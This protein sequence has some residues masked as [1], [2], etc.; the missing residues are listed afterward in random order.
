[1]NLFCYGFVPFMGEDSLLLLDG[2]E[3]WR[4]VELMN[5]NTWIN[6]QYVFM[7]LSENVQIIFHE[8]GELLMDQRVG[9]GANM[10]IPVQMIVV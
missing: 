3:G 9:L 1:M 6:S 7:T 4:D 8:E 2:R 5:H 10:A